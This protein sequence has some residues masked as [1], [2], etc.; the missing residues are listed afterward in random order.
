MQQSDDPKSLQ[1]ALLDWYRG[2]KRDLPWRR[3]KDPYSI[4]V[5][6]I[7]LQQTRVATVIPYYERFLQ[8]FPTPKALAEAKEEEVLKLWEGLGYYSRAK[9][10]HA[11]AKEV[12]A[13]HNGVVP[14][15]PDAV[16]SLP[17]IGPYTAGAILSI[18][19]DR[20]EAVL[21]GNVARVLSRIF[22]IEGDPRLPKQTKKLWELSR[23]IVPTG[24]A[25]DMNQ[26]LM[27]L[28]ARI[29]SPKSPACLAC[30]LREVCEG[31]RTATPEIFGAREKKGEVH[32]VEVVGVLLTIGPE[33]NKYI[34]AQRP[35]KG[36]LADLWELPSARRAEN[37]SPEACAR[38]AIKEGLGL[39][40]SEVVTLKISPVEHVF[41]HLKMRLSLC[42]AHS[43]KAPLGGAYPAFEMFPLKTTGEKPLPAI[44]IKAMQALAPHW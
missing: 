28:G 3:T 24:E 29:C 20:D 23:A 2:N 7:M 42:R 44:T 16:R 6:E 10:L 43:E 39:D 9:N 17:G 11:G 37:E 32:T 13:K 1:K 15:D 30:P 19:F 41:T 18:A 40:V 12:T 26:A 34:L 21:D 8:K 22:G 4:W 33:K 35:S 14:N 31:A 5:S 38:R 36:L 27:E 25:G